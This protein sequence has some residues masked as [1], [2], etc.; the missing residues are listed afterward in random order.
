LSQP[1]IPEAPRERL[2]RLRN[3][4]LHLHKSLLDSE[5]AAYE[6]DVER[7]SS[8]GQFLD[9]L[10]NDP[11]FGWLRELSQFI[12]VVDETLD[13]DETLTADDATRLIGQARELVSPAED[14]SRFARRYWEAMQRDPAAVLAHRDMLRCFGEL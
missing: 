9:L 11:W 1:A 6:R 3:G 8:T 13:Q 5:R 2:T 12:V 10:L 7:I 4:L 14:G